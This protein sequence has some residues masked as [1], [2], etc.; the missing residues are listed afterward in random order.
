MIFYSMQ[1]VIKATKN[2]VSEIKKVMVSPKVDGDS[3]IINLT[4]LLRS[5]STDF[6]IASYIYLASFRNYSDYAWYGVKD[7]DLS[8]VPDIDLSKY[9]RNPLLKISS[10]SIKF[11]YE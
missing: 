10:D 6:D 1:K 4:P 7:L 5:S 3:F 11:K 9:R 2:N 8:L